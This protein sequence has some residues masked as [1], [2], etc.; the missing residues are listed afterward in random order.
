MKVRTED[1]AGRRKGHGRRLLILLVLLVGVTLMARALPGFS[2]E[3]RSRHHRRGHSAYTPE[4]LVQRAERLLD[5]IDATAA[6]R[7]Q[8]QEI[9]RQAAEQ[10][11]TLK[12]DG[13]RLHSEFV[14]LL[15]A[16]SLDMQATASLRNQ[17]VQL[18]AESMGQGLDALVAIAGIL[19]PEQRRRLAEHGSRSLQH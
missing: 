6:Q 2:Q 13:D 8:A 1:H 15:A 9:L 16:G 17:A 19:T 18:A 12:A 4:D 10:L 3:H 7:A 11:A 14:R 5:E